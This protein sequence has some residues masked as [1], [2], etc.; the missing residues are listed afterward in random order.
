MVSAI[1][2][3]GIYMGRF[4]CDWTLEELFVS[5]SLLDGWCARSRNVLPGLDLVGSPYS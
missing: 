5:R 1:L 3:N 4:I 2:T